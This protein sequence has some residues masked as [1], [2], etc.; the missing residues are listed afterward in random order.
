MLNDGTQATAKA[1]FIFDYPDKG[2]NE[3]LWKKQATPHHILSIDGREPLK[4][5]EAV[6]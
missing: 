2:R 6:F 1:Y 3:E 4:D 5:G